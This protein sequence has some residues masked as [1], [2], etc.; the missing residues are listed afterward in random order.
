M[1]VILGRLIVILRRLI[2]IM[3]RRIQPRYPR[4]PALLLPV[5]RAVEWPFD[6]V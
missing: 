5:A 2:V 1:I 3:Q 4:P 6:V